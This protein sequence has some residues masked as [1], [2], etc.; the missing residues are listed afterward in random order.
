MYTHVRWQ[1]MGFFINVNSWLLKKQIKTIKKN[2]KTYF[3]QLRWGSYFSRSMFSWSYFSWTVMRPHICHLCV[4]VNVC[5]QTTQKISE[6]TCVRDTVMDY[7]QNSPY[8]D[9]ITISSIHKKFSSLIYF[10]FIT[11]TSSFLLDGTIVKS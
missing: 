9:L 3:Y 8:T 7:L 4:S 10:I 1:C 6:V 5:K 2:S 11:K